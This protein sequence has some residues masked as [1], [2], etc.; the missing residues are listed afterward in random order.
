MF[1]MMVTTPLFTARTSPAES[2]AAIVSW[3]E[4]QSH[5]DVVGAHASEA[6]EALNRRVSP[7][8]RVA[9]EGLTCGPIAMQSG[10]VS[11]GV[12]VFDAWSAV[13]ASAINAVSPTA[14]DSRFIMWLSP[15][16]A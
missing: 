13:H 7:T 12:A 6:K 11:R 8:C 9:I 2:T 16:R 15:V 5:A 10:G 1:A 3:L 4:V 14:I